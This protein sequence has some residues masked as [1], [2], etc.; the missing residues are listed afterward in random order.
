MTKTWCNVWRHDAM[1]KISVKDKIMIENLR[2]EKRWSSRTSFRKT[3][4]TLNMFL[5]NCFDSLQ[6]LYCTSLYCT[7]A[8]MPVYLCNMYMHSADV[9]DV[10][11]QCRVSDQ[12]FTVRPSWVCCS[13]L[14]TPATQ[15]SVWMVNWSSL[16]SYGCIYAGQDRWRLRPE[17]LPNREYVTGYV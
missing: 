13:Q 10:L 12:D 8:Q 16:V 1:G 4:L 2:K 7:S 5:N 11:R 3:E 15:W 17:F 14:S 6:P 9:Q